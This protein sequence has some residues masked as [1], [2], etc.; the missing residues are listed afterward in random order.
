MIS[1]QEMASGLEEKLADLRRL[2]AETLDFGEIERALTAVMNTLA[3]RVLAELLEAVLSGPALLAPLKWLGGQR[4]LRFK[5]YRV[6]RLRLGQGQES[7]VRVPYFIK[8]AA[9]GRRGNRRGRKGSGCYLGL[10]ALGIIERCSPVLLS[11][12][13]ELAL[14]SPSFEVARGVL[15]RRGLELNVKTLRRLCQVLGARG[16]T[17][18]GRV[19][20]EGT[21]TLEGRTLV[22]GIDGGRLRERRRNRGRKAAGQ[23]RQ[24]YH[25]DWK[26]PKLFTLYVLDRNGQVAKDFRPLHDAPLGDHEALFGLLER[27][28]RAL[29]L[30]DVSRVVFCGDGAEWIWNDVTKLLPQLGLANQTVYQGLDDTHAKQNLTEIIDGLPKR[31]RSAERQQRWKT[32]LWQGDLAA[33]EGEIKASFTAKTA[34][35]RALRKG[36]T[37]FAANAERMQYQHFQAQGIPCGSGCVERAIRRVIH[38]RLKAPGTFWSREMGEC[39]L[40]LRSQLLSGR[41]DVMLDNITRKSA[42]Q[43]HYHYVSELAANDDVLLQ[44]A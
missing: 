19:S 29:P 5:E 24:G 13:V 34:R 35:E 4:G 23:K 7:E 42:K 39:F 18:R 26:E 28:L 14:L 43:I 22:I 40:F 41:W 8:A 11:E 3:A 9:K 16:L 31:R 25:S 27:Y 32:L 15:S 21:E 33:L 36:R 6:V 20:L 12:V 10:D 37:Y 2:L 30:S 44:A 1:L 38:L 17:E